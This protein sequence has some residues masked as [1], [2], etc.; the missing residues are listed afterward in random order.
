MDLAPLSDPF[1]IPLLGMRRT[2][3]LKRDSIPRHNGCH[4]VGIYLLVHPVTA[5]EEVPL[6]Y[7][8]DNPR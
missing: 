1:A 5:K 8:N 6:A 2:Y 3:I 7:V 4:S